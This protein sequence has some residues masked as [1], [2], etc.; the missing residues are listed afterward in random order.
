[1]LPF[2]GRSVSAAVKGP[3][4]EIQ[5]YQHETTVMA[6]IANRSLCFA[7]I[8]KGD[9]E[10]FD[11]FF[12]H[13]Y[14]KLVQFANLWVSS[15]E[16]AEDIVADVLTNLLVHKE[17]VFVLDHFEAY[18]YSSVKNRALSTLKKLQKMVP[19]REEDHQPLQVSTSDPYQLL[20]QREFL[21]F[22]AQII[23]NL[24]PKRQ[25]VFKMI[26]EEGLSYREVADLLDIS[27]RTVEVH[28]KLAVKDLRTR[29]ENYL[30]RQ[31]MHQKKNNSTI[32]I[33][34]SPLLVHLLGL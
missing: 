14:P 1:M 19:E 23:E 16:Q 22:V 2:C 24:P 15:R 9:K 11:V 17:R 20:E 18:L 12:K 13:Y 30:N 32:N 33:I 4:S 29:I 5:S 6:D 3:G 34:F 27:E 8:A 26:R 28:L 21:E 25:M 10:A 7:R 31:V